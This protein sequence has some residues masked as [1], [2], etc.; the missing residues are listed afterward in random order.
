MTLDPCD[1][2]DLSDDLLRSVELLLEA[3]RE[4][5]ALILI[6]S[7]AD[8]FG[9]LD[10]DDGE[11]TRAS[12]VDWSERYMAPSKKLGCSGL[13]LYSARCGLLHT[14]SPETRLTRGGQAREFI[15][16]TYPHVF[17]ED[18]IA[19]GPFVVHVGNLWLAFRNGT[20]RFVEDIQQEPLRAARVQRNLSRLY[21]TKTT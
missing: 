20:A 8:I 13:E 10:T 14:M 19:G 7:G 4:S 5:A 6:F 15:F 3:F 12:F 21:F 16:V 17:P 18:N 11:A 2:R 1:L 9:A